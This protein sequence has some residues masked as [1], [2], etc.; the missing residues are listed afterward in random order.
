MYM[1]MALG[2]LAAAVEDLVAER[3]E[4]RRR[5]VLREELHGLRAEGSD[6]RGGPT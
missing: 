3:L 5:E 1:W 6:R 4:A 2:V